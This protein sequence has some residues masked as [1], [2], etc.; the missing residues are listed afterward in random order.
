MVKIEFDS[1]DLSHVESVGCARIEAP[2]FNGLAQ[3]LR[4][5]Y[6]GLFCR[7]FTRETFDSEV[8]LFDKYKSILVSCAHD[9]GKL[10]LNAVNLESVVN[11]FSPD[12]LETDERMKILNFMKSSAMSV[13]DINSYLVALEPRIEP[14]FSLNMQA[15]FDL[16]LTPIG[17]VIARANFFRKT[18]HA[19]ALPYR[20]RNM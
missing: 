19:I 13:K 2:S 20:M 5:S 18:G 8:G 11:H 3:N 17:A 1:P 7:G 14:L 6:P 4:T 9:S 10:Q 15:I 12:T 16:K